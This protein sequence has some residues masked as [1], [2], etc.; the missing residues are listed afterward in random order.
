MPA[1]RISEMGLGLHASC[2]VCQSRLPSRAR[3]AC[4]ADVIAASCE[5]GEKDDIPG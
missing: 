2:Y 4:D 5:D 3:T 1:L